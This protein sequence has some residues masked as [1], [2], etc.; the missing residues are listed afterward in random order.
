MAV[1][2]TTPPDCCEC[3]NCNTAPTR[4]ALFLAAPPETTCFDALAPSALRVTPTVRVCREHSAS[5]G[6]I[7]YAMLRSVGSKR[8]LKADQLLANDSLLDALACWLR[9]RDSGYPIFDHAATSEGK[10]R[11]WSWAGTHFVWWIRVTVD[12]GRTD[13]P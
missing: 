3:L 12:D 9:L 6:S 5:A 10:A 8:R 11:G 7:L 13:L 2:P 1:L 4:T